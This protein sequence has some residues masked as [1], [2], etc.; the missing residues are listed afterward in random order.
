MAEITG[1]N[2]LQ[3]AFRHLQRTTGANVRRAL[4][5]CGLLAVREAKANAPRAVIAA[6]ADWELQTGG[7]P[8]LTRQRAQVLKSNGDQMHA[9]QYGA[10]IAYS[11][12]F[13]AKTVA[14]TDGKKSLAVP[15]AGLVSNGAHV[16]SVQV[17][18]SQ[19]DAPTLEVA[20]HRHAALDGTPAD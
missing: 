13:A 2:E 12:T 19:T 1:I 9:G 18:Y 4:V 16:D 6:L 5:R 17:A 7:N 3:A 14:E 15:G 10:Q 8:T 20:S 11:E